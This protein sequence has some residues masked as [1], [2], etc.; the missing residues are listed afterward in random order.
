MSGPDSPSVPEPTAEEQALQ[1][2]QAELLRMQREELEQQSSLRDALIP[3]LAQEMG[4]SAVMEDGE[5]VGFEPTEMGQ[6][7]RELQSELLD[8]Q[9]MALRGELPESPA[10]ERDIREQETALRERLRSKLGP[11]FET[12][13]PGLEAIGE[14][15][16]KALIARDAAR[17]G[18]LTTASNIMQGMRAGTS[19]RVG[20]LFG[21]TGAT[22]GFGS[23]A[24][25]FGRA[26]LPFQDQR[27]AEFN[28]AQSRQQA[29][30]NQT[31]A[32]S[33]AGAGVG[34]L[35]AGSVSGGLGA[36]AGAA[37]GGATGTLLGT[38][39]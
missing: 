27:S 24:G 28:A 12:S 21:V 39:F 2:E 4:F 1:Q 10:L 22:T 14:M 32:F 23:L 20:D 6:Q 34:A 17:R 5:V 31:R 25:G 3:E 30:A 8:R 33:S 9:L 38:V 26:Q 37:I 29:Q 13:T 19:Q 36:P 15:Q 16:E 35:A 18:D 11:G 7:R